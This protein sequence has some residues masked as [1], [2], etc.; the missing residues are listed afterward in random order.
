MQLE[1][2]TTTD[3]KEHLTKDTLVVIPVGSTEQHGPQ[4]PLG[5]DYLLATHVA[6]KAC[7]EAGAIC[8]PPIP[9][10]IS[11]HHS[12]FAG[13]L[14]V[15]SRLFVDLLLEYAL[16]LVHYGFNHIIFLNGHGG[17]VSALKEVV[18]ILYFKYKLKAATVNW[19][20][21]FDK[22]LA[23]TLF[24]NMKLN[25][26]EAVETSANLAV[27]PHLVHLDRLSDVTPAAEWGRKVADIDIPA[28]TH[29]FASDGVVG[30]LENISG[31]SGR[32]LLDSSIAK[33]VEFIQ[34]FREYN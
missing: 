1:E 26:A 32:K 29:E 24:P 31:D 33:F 3:V 16:C 15:S 4:N 27:H 20:D 10:G 19:Y 7:K 5:T 34:A 8:A 23:T 2:M 25:H 18:S 12:G 11:E 30:S 9:V 21:L 28:Y 22:D 14:W 13:T 17:N 6:R